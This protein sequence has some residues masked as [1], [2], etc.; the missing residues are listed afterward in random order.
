MIQRILAAL[1]ACALTGSGARACVPVTLPTGCRMH[2]RF[3]GFTAFAV[4]MLSI[5]G[6][7]ADVAKPADSP[8]AKQVR[9][10]LDA[11]NSGDRATLEAYRQANFSPQW[12]QAP[13]VD[14]GLYLHKKF[15]GFDLLESSE[16]QPNQLKAW[17]RAKD[18]DTVQELAMDVEPQAPHRITFLHIDWGN[19]PQ[20][21]LPARLTESAAVE[22]WRADTA[23]R[24]AADKFSGAIL[25]ARGDTVLLREAYGLADRDNKVS[26]TVDTI[27]RTASTSK[28]FT[29][30]AVMR[31]VQ[32]GKL[33]LDDPIAKIVP[34][35]A[36]KPIGPA[37]IHQ[38]L[39][40]SSGAGDFYGPLL[41]EHKKQLQDHDDFVSIFGG[42]ALQFEPGE[43]ADYSNLGYIWL[44][45]AIEHASG[46]SFYDYL[47]EVV[48]KPAGMVRTDT[49]PAD[50]DMRGRAHGYMRPPGTRE[51]V[52]AAQYLD[53]RPDGAGGAWS[54]IDD[55]QRFLSAL[56]RNRILDEK[57]TRLMLSPKAEQWK[58]RDYGYGVWIESYARTARVIGHP[59]GEMGSNSEAWFM[60]DTGYQ[61]IVLSNFD[62]GAAV[63]VAEFIRAR[64]PIR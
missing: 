31:L 20:K 16:V 35:L 62:P 39:S 44:G 56:R 28:M 64:L 10:L 7:A 2:F 55:M 5:P 24:A 14:D 49:P 61:I 48:F 52:S 32:D 36:G 51:W 18:S 21:Y 42:A 60:P 23:R 6:L 53:Y 26:N 25:L 30:A 54:T 50:V 8:A 59:G 38:L 1:L 9:Q 37:T 40:H 19:T 22:A 12:K 34:A 13:G 46:K 29:G 45:A 4:V 33:K 11:L 47:D 41:D 15:G 58:G 43:K 27:F 3:P 63:V 57:Y 17:L